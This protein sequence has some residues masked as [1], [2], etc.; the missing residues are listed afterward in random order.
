MY[1]IYSKTDGSILRHVHNY[2]IDPTEIVAGLNGEFTLHYPNE[3][4]C[5]V[6]EIPDAEYEALDTANIGKYRISNGVV[7]ENPNW[8]DPATLEQNRILDL[9]AE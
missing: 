4:N 6:F 9:E 3:C 8:V 7:E 5:D 1:L 2:R